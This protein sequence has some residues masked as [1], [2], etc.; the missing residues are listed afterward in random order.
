[1]LSQETANAAS[2]GDTIRDASIPGLHLRAFPNSKGFYLSYRHRGQQRKPK[3]GDYPTLSITAARRIAKEMLERVARGE[4]PSAE[5]Q[6]E[7]LTPTVAD[8]IDR[9]LE[10]HA[11]GKKSG[12][13]DNRMAKKYVRAKLGKL[14]VADVRVTDIDDLHASM[15]KTPYQANRVLSMLSKMFALSILW[16][17]RPI[18]SNPCDPVVQFPEKK[19]KRYAD[20]DEATKIVERLRFYESEY[21]EQVAFLWLLFY[22]GARPIELATAMPEHLQGTK[23]VLTEHKTDGTGEDR[24]IQLPPQALAVLAK[25]KRKKGETLLRI[26]SPRHLW[27]KIMEETGVK[28]LRR[29][30]LRHTFASIGL[31]NGKSLAQVGELLGHRSAETTK[32]Y[33]HLIDEKASEDASDIADAFDA[34]SK[35]KLRIVG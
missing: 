19:R 27:T 24:V 16:E 26:K 10:R 22:T 12:G 6:A 3:L 29:Y 17:M 2:P 34:F 30:D 1:M 28:N 23:L 33:A 31:S 21:P 11:V 8:L 14:K 32:R 9:Y 5:R 35:P 25:I 15:K 20:R 4:D 18:N 13:E 7:R